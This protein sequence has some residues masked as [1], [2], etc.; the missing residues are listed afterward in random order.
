MASFKCAPQL[1]LHPWISTR[2][3]VNRLCIHPSAILNNNLSKN[4]PQ[5]SSESLSKLF[6]S[7]VYSGYVQ[8]WRTS[9]LFNYHLL[10]DEGKFSKLLQMLFF[11]SFKIF[12]EGTVFRFRHFKL[13]KLATLISEFR[14][15]PQ[16]VPREY[17][18]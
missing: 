1:L 10:E 11:L 16:H 14:N 8:R 18:N 2:P 9:R 13:R 6:G 17:S 4:Q 12:L 5:R 15:F 7:R 3:R